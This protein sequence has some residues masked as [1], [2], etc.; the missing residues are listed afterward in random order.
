MKK[1]ILLELTGLMILTVVLFP[2]AAKAY[3]IQDIPETRIEDDFVLG[4]GKIEAFLEPGEKIQKELLIT[5]RIGMEMEFKVVVEDFKGSQNPKEPAVLLGDE[6]GPFSLKNYLKPELSEFTLQHGERM[7]LPVEI[8]IP[9]NAEPG[10]L[11]GSVLILSNPPREE[12]KAE[13]EKAMGQVK[14]VS[15]IGALLFIRVAGDV[16]ESGFLEDFK[17]GKKYYEKGP[18]NFEILFENDG[19]VHLNPYGKI[20]IVNLLGKKIDEIEITPFFVMP[21]SRRMDEVRW[22]SNF[23]FGKY[24]ALITLNRGYGEGI[25]D[26]KSVVFWVLPWKI[27]LAALAVIFLVIF[28][29]RWLFG[30][31]EIKRKG[32]EESKE[33]NKSKES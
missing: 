33:S 29:I 2:V 10:G 24:K 16:D 15:R 11:Y 1:F 12:L 18:I 30:K 4:P 5:N 25:I 9:E 7:V 8:S 32:P 3:I 31:F 23:L 6:K 17:S 21:D 20:E 22:N 19:S 28:F 13:K 27:I 26:Q 14:I